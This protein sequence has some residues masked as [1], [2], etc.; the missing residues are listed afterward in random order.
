MYLGDGPFQFYAHPPSVEYSTRAALDTGWPDQ[1]YS[2][3][4]TNVYRYWDP[5]FGDVIEETSLGKVDLD[6]LAGG[7]SVPTPVIAN[8][9][10]LQAW[11]RTVPLEVQWQPFA[12]AG[13]A[14][15][16]QVARGG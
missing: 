2:F 10:R 12:G 6:L 7:F 11:P 8:F 15:F 4:L 9:A 14:D 3:A 1:V 13:T 5:V 16:V